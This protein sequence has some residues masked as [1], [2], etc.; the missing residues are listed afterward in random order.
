MYTREIYYIVLIIYE[1]I[2]LM[3]IFAN[4]GREKIV[5]NS[6]HYILVYVYLIVNC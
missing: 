4:I 5:D 1:H 6:S 3:L 2:M